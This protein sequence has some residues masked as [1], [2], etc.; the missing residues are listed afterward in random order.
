[1]AKTPKRKP[2]AWMSET[3]IGY[4]FLTPE[5]TTIRGGVETAY[6]IPAGLNEWGPWMIHPEA[7]TARDSEDCGPGGWHVMAKLSAVHAPKRWWVWLAEGRGIIG[8][9]GEKFRCREIRLK[10]ITLRQ[11]EFCFRAFGAPRWANL[12]SANLGSA[13]LGWANL[14]SANLSSANLSSANLGSANLGSAN[15]GWANLSSANLGS[16][17]LRWADGN[18]FTVLPSGLIVKNGKIKRV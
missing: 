6:P 3:R 1:M 18:E 5:G 12:S 10:R 4:K 14:G 2:P 9:S 15:L 13:N 16:A 11:M 8:V 17:D 7:A